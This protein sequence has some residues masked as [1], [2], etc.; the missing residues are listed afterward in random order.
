[1]FIA[2]DGGKLDLVTNSGLGSLRYKVTFK[3][4]GGHS[5]G[6]FG[7]V[8]PAFA[9]GDAIA[10]LGQLKVPKN[11]KVSYNVGVV[12]GGTSVNSIPFEV[13]MEVDMRS[14]SPEELRKVDAQFKTIVEQAVAEENTA[15]KTTFGSITAE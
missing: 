11:P 5:W 12:S 4:P 7:T 1:R 6:A 3:G 14:V 13:A 15:R 10:R 8:S 2:I 9:M